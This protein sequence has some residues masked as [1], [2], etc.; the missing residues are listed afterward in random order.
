MKNLEE[1]NHR[2]WIPGPEET[3][4]TYL[5]RIEALDHFYSHPPHDIDHFL[6]SRDWKRANEKLIHL[7]DFAPDW[8]VAYYSNKKLSFFQGAATW[9]SEKNHLRIPLVQ[10]K[11]KFEEGGLFK[12]YRREEVLAHEAIHAA[13]MQFD[14]PRFEEMFA[15]KTSPHFFRRFFGPLFEKPWEANLFII[16]AFLPIIAEAFRLFWF[17]HPSFDYVLAP[18]LTFLSYLLARL[19]V[20]RFTL[21]L[22]L[23]RLKGMLKNPMKKWAVALR[24]KD[25]EIFRFAYEKKDKLDAFLKQEKTLR[26]QLLKDTYFKKS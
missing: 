19:L 24:L 20:L 17:D 9:I 23:K 22:A 8:I 25:R 2:G 13:R 18:T 14:E 26:L 15:Y 7:Y 21:A 11:K 6:T 10:L 5:K 1:Y 3:K 12:L 4:E 16:L